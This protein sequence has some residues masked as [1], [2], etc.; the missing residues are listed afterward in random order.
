[1]NSE[2]EKTT[3]SKNKVRILIQDRKSMLKLTSNL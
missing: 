1:M 2:M 3:Q